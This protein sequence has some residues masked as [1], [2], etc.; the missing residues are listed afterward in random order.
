ML[1]INPFDWSRMLGRQLLFENKTIGKKKK[2][3]NIIIDKYM[4][5]VFPELSGEAY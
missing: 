3:I 5:R 4:L 2:N 1:K